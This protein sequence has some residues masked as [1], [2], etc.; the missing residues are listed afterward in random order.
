MTVYPFLSSMFEVNGIKYVPVSPSER[1]CDAIDC[2]FDSTA[3]DVSILPTVNYRGVSMNVLNVKPYLCYNNKYVKNVEVNFKGPLP[4]YLF[5]SCSSL[6]TVKV[7]DNVTAIGNR[8]FSGCISLQTIKLGENV[9]AI[10]EYAF[11]SCDSLNTVEVNSGSIGA[12]AFGSCTSLNYVALGDKVSSIGDYAFSSCSSLKTLLLGT[13]IEEIGNYAFE[14]CY[15]LQKVTIPNSTTYLGTYSFAYCSNLS[16]FRVGSKVNKILDYTFQNCKSLFS[17]T[18]PKATTEIQ[19]KA[20]SGCTGLKTILIADRDTELKLGSNGS[21]PLFADC[22]LDSVYIGGDITYNTGKSYGYSPFY[23]HKTLR[24]I[25][26]TDKET[27]ISPNEFYGCSN[28]KNVRIGDG[29]TTIGDWAFSGCSSLTYF[30][31]GTKM[32]TIGKEAFSDCTS[33]GRIISKTATP[34]ACGSQALDDINKWDCQL[35]VPEGCLS[36][37]QAAD[38][39]KDFFFTDERAMEESIEDNPFNPETEKCATPIIELTDGH[40]TFSCET[41]G[42]EYIYEVTNPDVK[43]GNGEDVTLGGVYKVSV[44]ATKP[45]YDDSDVATL[46]FSF[47]GGEPCDSNH[48]GVVDVADI[49]TIIDKMA[50]QARMQDDIEE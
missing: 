18:I 39:W 23:G 38:Q 34:P 3:A 9:T 1:T 21:S 24:S 27:E 29:V 48:D 49:A 7:G 17:L 32:K 11:S 10:G 4:E 13:M 37:Y 41:E 46:E 19:G 22:P 50:S 6:Q 15:N 25:T 5:C 44:I 26:I 36:A 28:L 12:Y 47:G 30:T 40:L 20:F 43:K 33:V 14:S 2:A 16:E 42:V 8:S 45:G 35:S 31:F